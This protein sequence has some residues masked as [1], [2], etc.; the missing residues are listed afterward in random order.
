MFGTHMTDEFFAVNTGGDLAFVNG[1]LKVMLADGTVDRE[2]VR[3]AHRGVRRRC[4]RS[5]SGSRSPIS[6][7]S[8]ARRAPT[9]S[10]SPGCTA[11]RTRRCSSGRWGS[12]STNGA[13]TTWPRSSTSG[14]RAATSVAPAP[15]SCPSAGTRACRAAP[16]WA[17]TPPRSPAASTSTPPSPPRSPSSTA[18]RSATSPGITAEEMVEAGGRGEIDVLYSSG[19][20]FL[21]VLPDPAAVEAALARVPLR[22]HQDIVVSSQMLVDPGDV[23]VLL[24]AATRY[25]QRDGGTETTT[26]RRIAFSPEIDGR[27]PGEVRSE[28]EI[29]VDLARR[30]DPERAA[31]CARSTSGSGDPRRDRSRRTRVLGGRAVDAPPATPSSGVARVSARAARSPPPDGKAHFLAVAPS[32]PD[33]PAGSF[34]LSTRRGKQFNTMVH[35]ERDPL[36]GAMRDALFMAPSDIARARPARRRPRRR[37][38]RRRRDAGPAPRERAAARQR[39]GVLPRRQRAPARRSPRPGVG[40]ARLQRDRHRRGRAAVTPDDLL[41]LFDV[42]SAAQRGALGDARPARAARPHRPARPVPARPRRRRRHP[43]GARRRRRPRAERGVGLERARRTPRSPWSSIRSTAP[44][45]ARGNSRTGRSRC[46]RSTPTVRCARWC[47]TAPPARATPRC[48]AGRAARRRRRSRRRPPWRSAAR[49]SRCRG[50][51][52]CR[53][54]WRQFRALGSAALALCD[55]AAGHLDGYLDGIVDQHAPW[56]YLGGL[57]VCR[58]AG[59]LVVDADGREL[60]VLDARRAPSAPRRRYRGDCS[61]RCTTGVAP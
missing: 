15:A 31:L 7:D 5:S 47:R 58:E 19:G 32:E 42:A 13:P 11:R 17:R 1:V 49:W 16:R 30:V 6:N 57:L 26:E 2:F 29:F 39:A 54:A 61:P 21:E 9:W 25:E 55:V 53:S 36:T 34:V 48:G 56:D 35:E 14:W 10:A 28:W 23:V 18:S 4:S 27:R 37:A 22:V 46:A 41:A 60:V 45:T 3:D 38:L 33:V 43:P 8:R 51:R 59:A 50:G 20:N 44:P 52:P 40:R 24:P 12:P